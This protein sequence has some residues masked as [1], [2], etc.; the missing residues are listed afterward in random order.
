MAMTKEFIEN[1]LKNKSPEER[2]EIARKG[3]EARARK[4][5]ERMALQK[6]MRTLLNQNVTNEKQKQI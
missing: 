2:R 6:C 4:K 3:A 5:N 1:N